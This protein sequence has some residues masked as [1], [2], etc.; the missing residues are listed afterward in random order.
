[1]KDSKDSILILVRGEVYKVYS[2]EWSKEQIET[3][4]SATAEFSSDFSDFY[5]SAN[6]AEMFLDILKNI[7]EL[8]AVPQD[9]ELYLEII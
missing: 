9:Q 4:V 7:F 2:D 3:M 8:K 1:M 5:P 6:H